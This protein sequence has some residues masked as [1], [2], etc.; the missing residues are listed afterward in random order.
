MNR[1]ERV[2]QEIDVLPVEE[3]QERNEQ[4]EW[5]NLMAAQQSS[6]AVVW[7]NDEDEV[8]NHAHSRTV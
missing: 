4:D 7:E 1:A 8:W 2:Q 5:K 3:Q 6:L